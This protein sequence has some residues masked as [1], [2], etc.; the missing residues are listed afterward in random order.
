MS[1]RHTHSPEFNARVAMA[2]ISSHKTLQEIAA[3]GAERM[4]QESQW[5]GQLLEGDREFPGRR[6]SPTH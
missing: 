4:T 1:N 5:M 3:F 2:A 6:R